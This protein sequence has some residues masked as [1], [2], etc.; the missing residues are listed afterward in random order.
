M[1][2]NNRVFD[3][4]KEGY[5]LTNTLTIEWPYNKSLSWFLLKIREAFSI[6]DDGSFV[7]K[8]SENCIVAISHTLP[9]GKYE[10]I[11]TETS[12]SL[13]RIISTKD[14]LD[15]TDILK[16][17]N[18][19]LSPNETYHLSRYNQNSSIDKVSFERNM[20]Q[21]ACAD[22][23]IANER[24]WLAWTR[25]SLNIMACSFT[26][27]FLDDWS[28]VSVYGKILANACAI[29]YAIGFAGCFI[30]GYL[31]YR[32]FSKLLYTSALAVSFEELEVDDMNAQQIWSSFLAFLM[33]FSS[34]VYLGIL[35]RSVISSHTGID[36]VD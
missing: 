36:S 21:I 9:S 7:L 4:K 29:G 14:I 17:N 10:I 19:D 11:E 6:T 13:A 34:V 12:E 28:K 20:L 5:G 23:L 8:D 3:L 35:R 33:T 25:T 16:S 30:V 27:I 18:N 24:T 26:F 31:R 22:A 15:R 32:K 2:I 1:I